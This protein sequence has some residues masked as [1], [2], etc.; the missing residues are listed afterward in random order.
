[1]TVDPANFFR[2]MLGQWETMAN[3]FGGQAMRTPEAARA[4][5]AA[6]TATAQIQEA[7]REAMGKTLAAYNMPSR[8]EVTGLSERLGGVEDRLARIETLLA[9]IAGD[10][11]PAAPPRPKPTRSK[12]PGTKA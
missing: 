7:T 2:D 8:E 9:R 10:T 4:M 11:A 6:T 5:G 12:Q 3:Q 1:M